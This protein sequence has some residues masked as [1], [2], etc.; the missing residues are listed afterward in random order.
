M[1]DLHQGDIIRVANYKVPFLI[2]SKNAFIQATGV[3][4]V[5]PII[6]NLTPGPVHIP[7]RGHHGEEGTVPCEQ[8][9]LLDPEARHCTRLDSLP[10]DT[11]MDISDTIQGIFEYD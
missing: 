11:I 5:C 1:T 9:K 7:I 4:H 3:F 6:K 2:V 8:I 10:Y